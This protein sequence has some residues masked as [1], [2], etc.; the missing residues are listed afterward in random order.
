MA[1]VIANEFAEA[2]ST[3]HVAALAEIGL[4]LFAVTLAFNVA[5]RILV[6]RVRGPE[7]ALTRV[8]RPDEEAV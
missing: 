6:S 7:T 1:S 4:L 8:I 3:L 5:A 2:T